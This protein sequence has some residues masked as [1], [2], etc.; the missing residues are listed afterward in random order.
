VDTLEDIEISNKPNKNV[1][2]E[3]KKKA[4]STT[5]Q[6]LSHS[7]QILSEASEFT[8]FSLFCCLKKT[9][10]GSRILRTQ[11]LA[12]RSTFMEV[13]TNIKPLEIIPEP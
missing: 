11:V 13:S 8:I 2:Q 6:L 5:K 10:N 4:L 1:D 7:S 12:G 3:S 9:E